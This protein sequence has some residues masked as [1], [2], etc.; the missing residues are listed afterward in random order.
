MRMPR[1]ARARLECDAGAGRARRIPSLKQWIDPHGPGEPVGWT[2]G[3]GLRAGAFDVH[4]ANRNKAY[5]GAVVGII[6]EGACE[7]QFLAQRAREHRD[8]ADGA[9]PE[10]KR[11][12]DQV[13]E[14]AL[15]PGLECSETYLHLLPQLGEVRT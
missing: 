2:F 5:G 11:P 12:L 6:D 13:A 7:T 14:A 3:R 9:H 4:G 8:C 15:E 10:D 1:R